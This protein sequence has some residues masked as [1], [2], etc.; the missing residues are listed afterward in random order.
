LRVPALLK[1]QH[2]LWQRL[3][4]KLESAKLQHSKLEQKKMRILNKYARNFGDIVLYRDFNFSKNLLNSKLL[5]KFINIKKGS[6]EKN[7]SSISVYRKL[8]FRLM[9]FVNSW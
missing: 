3:R 6:L 5:T 7:Y 2:G 4:L 9:I 8:N 1:Q